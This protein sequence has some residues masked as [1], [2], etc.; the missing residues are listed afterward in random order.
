MPR[1]VEHTAQ[2]RQ[3][4]FEVLR[5]RGQTERVGVACGPG[6]PR[7]GGLCCELTV[8]GETSTRASRVDKSCRRAS[9]LP[10]WDP[11]LIPGT[12]WGPEEGAFGKRGAVVVY[13]PVETCLH[14]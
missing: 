6:R 13:R 7:S 1:N 2:L 10:G 4:S 8:S 12:V 11:L 5:G 14:V 3:K 9:A